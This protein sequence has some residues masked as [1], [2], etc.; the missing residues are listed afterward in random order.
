MAV[1]AADWRNGLLKNPQ[2]LPPSDDDEDFRSA[3]AIFPDPPKPKIS[4]HL[5]AETASFSNSPRQNSSLFVVVVVGCWRGGWVACFLGSCASEVRG[6]PSGVVGT[7]GMDLI[8]FDQ[9]RSHPTTFFI[10]FF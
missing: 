10:F 3:M 9:L 5:A 6:L 1:L 2:S 8:V 7:Q 4:E